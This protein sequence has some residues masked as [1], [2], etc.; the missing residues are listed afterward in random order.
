[1]TNL[2]QSIGEAMS[3]LMQDMTHQLRVPLNSRQG[4][5]E[6][7]RELVAMSISQDRAYIA[8]LVSVQNQVILEDGPFVL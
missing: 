2:R 3:E 8:L 6:S 1:M 5:A 7:E 4:F